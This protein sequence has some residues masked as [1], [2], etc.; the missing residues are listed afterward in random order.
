[1]NNSI[2]QL[3]VLGAI[4]VFLILKLRS[5]L[6]TRD[7]FEK[8]P[9]PA[10]VPTAPVARRSFEVI[11]GGPDRDITDFAAEG[12]ATAKALVQMKQAEPAFVVGEFLKGARSAYEMILTAFD[13]GEI[14]RI[15]ALLSPDVAQAFDAAAAERKARGLSVQTTV[16]GIRD[17]SLE[18]VTFDAATRRAEV[19][20]RYKAELTRVVKDDAGKVIDG[21]PTEIRRQGDSWTF[22]R[23]MGAPDPNWQLA[24]TGD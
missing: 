24:A 17:L 18:N 15:R 4:A 22:A 12:S 2:I 7:G 13:A 23:V 10:E 19:T 11:E 20:V 16:I 21:S 8:P 5:V 6:G 9:V 14:D 1:M 3:I